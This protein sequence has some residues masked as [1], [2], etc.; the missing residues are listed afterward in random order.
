MDGNMAVEALTV[1]N[2]PMAGIEQNGDNFY[3][4][5]PKWVGIGAI[6]GALLSMRT[7]PLK[8]A[9]EGALIAAGI[10]FVM[11]YMESR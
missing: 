6:A 2:G 11:H 7:Q 10:G 1:I 3:G 9:A 8:G 5:K 4:I